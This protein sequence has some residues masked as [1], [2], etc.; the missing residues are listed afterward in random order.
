VFQLDQ[1]FRADFAEERVARLNLD[2]PASSP[3]GRARLALGRWLI[4]VGDRLATE[5]CRQGELSLRA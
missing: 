2:W 5:P 4:R 1:L 3:P